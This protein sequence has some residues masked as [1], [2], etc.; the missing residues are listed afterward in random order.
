MPASRADSKPK[1][2]KTKTL[3]HTRPHKRRRAPQLSRWR[4]RRYRCGCKAEGKQPSAAAAAAAYKAKQRQVEPRPAGG[5]LESR[6]PDGRRLCCSPPPEFLP[7]TAFKP[8][9]PGINTHPDCLAPGSAGGRDGAGVRGGGASSRT[10]ATHFVLNGELP[11]TSSPVKPLSVR[12]RRRA[13]ATLTPPRLCHPRRC[14]SPAVNFWRKVDL[15]RRWM[16]SIFLTDLFCSARKYLSSRS[17]CFFSFFFIFQISRFGRSHSF[18]SL[19]VK[20]LL[21]LHI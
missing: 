7:K 9:H 15:Q 11:L 21:V 19:N 17:S 14:P 6:C 8:D 10:K 3:T 13:S 2:V 18:L 4:R 20:G 16:D 1:Q 12:L 5:R